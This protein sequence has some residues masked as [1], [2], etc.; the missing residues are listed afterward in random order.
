MWALPSR[1]ISSHRCSPKRFDAVAGADV[2]LHAA[3]HH[4]AGG[5]LL[6]LGL[7]VGHEAVAGGVAQQAAVARQPSVTRMPA[8]R[9][10]S[11]E[12]AP[13]PCCPGGNAGLEGDRRAD[14][15]VDDGVR[16]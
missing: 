10:W 5:E 2:L 6:L 7:V 3:R 1:V 13:P 12:T 16:A 15:F 14:A 8:G 9:W 4:V 11:G